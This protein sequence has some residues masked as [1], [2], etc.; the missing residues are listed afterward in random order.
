MNTIKNILIGF[1]ILV[2]GIFLIQ[3]FQKTRFREGLENQDDV[4]PPNAQLSCPKGCNAPTNANGKC[5]TQIYKDPDGKCYKLCSFECSDPLLN[6]QNDNYCDSCGKVRVY[7]DCETGKDINDNPDLNER[8]Q[9]TN[10]SSSSINTGIKNLSKNDLQGSLIDSDSAD[11]NTSVVPVM[12]PFAPPLIP[13]PP[14]TVIENNYYYGVLNPQDMTQMSYQNAVTSNPYRLGGIVQGV[15]SDGSSVMN[16]GVYGTPMD[17]NGAS[18]YNSNASQ[19][20]PPASQTPPP[21]SQTVPTATGMF[22]QEEEG[23]TPYDSI[24]SLKF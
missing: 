12:K 9:E 24:Y 11:V 5:D 6:C 18:I 16:Y 7:V 17:E 21:A 8:T 2:I 3:W 13:N 22:N 14:G 19:T 4:K 20:P 23:A 15:Q 10:Y 1:S